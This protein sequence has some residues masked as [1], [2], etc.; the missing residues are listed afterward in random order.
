MGENRKVKTVKNQ[1]LTNDAK[2]TNQGVVGSIP[3]SRT[4]IRNEINGLAPQV[5]TRLFFC[6]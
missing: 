3:A 1:L 2:A 5:L 6:G 4:I